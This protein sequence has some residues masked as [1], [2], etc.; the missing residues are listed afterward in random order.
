M[1]IMIII[2]MII[3]IGITILTYILNKRSYDYEKLTQYECGLENFEEESIV[4]SAHRDKFYIKF[5]IIAI[6]FLIFDLE[7]ILLYPVTLLFNKNN[8]YFNPNLS[9]DLITLITPHLE[10]IWGWEV[11]GYI[12]FIIFMIMLILGIIYETKKGVIYK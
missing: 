8:L 11:K 10:G 5:Y 7:S 1:S 4:E 3:S 9:L 6:I 12:I 2:S